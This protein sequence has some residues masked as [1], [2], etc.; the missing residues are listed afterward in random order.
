MPP[1]GLIGF[2]VDTL[3]PT[4]RI[5]RIQGE[6]CYP[7]NRINKT[8]GGHHYPMSGIQGGHCY[9]ITIG[10]KVGIVTLNQ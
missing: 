3:T 2:K 8:Q 10:P 7:I 4:N 6:H 1:T 9:P 5:D